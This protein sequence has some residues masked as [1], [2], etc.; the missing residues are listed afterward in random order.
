MEINH[1]KGGAFQSFYVNRQEYEEKLKSSA[2]INTTLEKDRFEKRNHHKA[3]AKKMIATAALLGG[4]LPVVASNVMKGRFQ[5]M[6]E[7]LKDPLM[8]AK[9]KFKAV[10]NMFEI[11]NFGEILASTTGAIAGGVASGVFLD[12]NPENREEK[13]REGVFEFLNNMTPT[14]LVAAGEYY[15]RKTGKFTSAPA[16][17][18]L[19]AGSVASGMFIANKTSNKINEKIFDKDKDKKEE[20]HCKRN[21]KP[22]D[23]LV[24]MDD[25][26]GLLVLAKIPLAKV[27]QAD[28]ILPFLYAKS[29]YEAGVM[30][31]NKPEDKKCDKI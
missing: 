2:S 30:Q 29:G 14:T 22:Q 21:F 8:K 1:I 17:A 25:I 13:Y 24:H 26:L 7:A 16:R 28:K 12:K 27:I 18:A 20:K 15:S 11:E 23:C 10:Y 6:S 5:I 3:K 19:I 9:D 4:I 31:K